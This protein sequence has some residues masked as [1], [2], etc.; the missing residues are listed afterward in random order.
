MPKNKGHLQW[1]PAAERLLLEW[2]EQNKGPD[3]P[4]RQNFDLALDEVATRLQDQFPTA[5]HLSGVTLKRRINDKLRRVWT[6]YRLTKYQTTP[7]TATVFFDEGIAALDQGKLGSSMA[8]LFPLDEE[9]QEDTA[10]ADNN[11]PPADQAGTNRKTKRKADSSID[12]VECSSP[13]RAKSTERDRSATPASSSDDSLRIE[14]QDVNEPEPDIQIHG[15]NEPQPETDDVD[16]P[17]PEIQTHVNAGPPPEVQPN[18]VED[19]ATAAQ[20]RFAGSQ[21]HLATQTPTSLPKTTPAGSLSSL[22]APSGIPGF[23][24]DTPSWDLVPLFCR[25]HYQSLQELLGTAVPQP[26]HKEVQTAMEGTRVR[27]E[28]AVSIYFRSARLAQDQPI[29][30]DPLHVYPEKLAALL[31][32]V[33]QPWHRHEFQSMQ[34]RT[35]AITWKHLAQSLVGQAVT[36][37]C[38]TSGPSAESFFSDSMENIFQDVHE[39]YFGPLMAANLRE[40][41]WERYIDKHL[42]PR[43]HERAAQMA[44]LALECLDH[45]L[46]PPTRLLG[47]KVVSGVRSCQP[48]NQVP[49]AD[50]QAGYRPF[51]EPPARADFLGRLTEIF[52]YALNW[53][54][55]ESK[56]LNITYGFEFPCFGQTFKAEKMD[57]RSGL[58]KREEGRVCLGFSPI[59]TWSIRRKVLGDYME[60]SV[61]SPATVLMIE[62]EE[63]EEPEE[64]VDQQP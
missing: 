52:E 22:L 17:Q 56:N 6:K 41:L 47:G 4:L 12:P 2:V 39:K 1:N 64:S 3:G 58:L 27:I 20:I 13:K 8:D 32:L 60:E 33:V 37:W 25:D 19:T 26:F 50:G 46:P 44:S 11:P 51:Q 30:F 62:S 34:T 9:P 15:V 14:T 36:A 55:G 59:V 53:R 48:V 7:F 23:G 18:V 57:R 24:P 45:I 54:M 31:N 21:T 16:E 42:L 5:A 61:V 35:T 28:S 63:P 29:I 38:L 49:T 40:K 43:N 10:S